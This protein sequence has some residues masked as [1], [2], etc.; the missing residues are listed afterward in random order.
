MD[1]CTVWQKVSKGPVCEDVEGGEDLGQFVAHATAQEDRAGQGLLQVRSARPVAD[2]DDLDALQTARVGQVLGDRG[3]CAP[4]GEGD[5]DLG[6]A[7]EGEGGATDDGARRQGVHAVPGAGCGGRRDDG[8]KVAAIYEVPGGLE[9]AGGHA[10]H[11]RGKG[12][13]H[14]DD[15][16]TGVLAALDVAASTWIFASDERPVSVPLYTRAGQAVSMPT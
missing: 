11:I 10:V 2:H 12:F 14:Y 13:G 6:V 16:H 1:S 3:G 4:A 5:A 8:R 9:R 7:R 15:T